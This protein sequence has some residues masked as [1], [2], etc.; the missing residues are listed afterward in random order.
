M[1]RNGCANP[2]S[3]ARGGRIVGLALLLNLLGLVSA[4]LPA[5]AAELTGPSPSG[6]YEAE[7]DNG[8]R[9]LMKEVTTSPIV[10]ASIWYQAGTKHESNGTTGLAHLLE[11]MMFKGTARY[12]KGVYDDLLEANGG[13][14][15]ATTWLDRTN[16]Y[17]VIAKDKLDLLL[18][19]EADRMRGALFTDQDLEDEMPVVRNEMEKG[20]DDP[21]TELDERIGSVAILEHP[22]HWPTIGWKSDVEATTAE[23]IHD[24]YNAFYRPDNAFLLILGDVPPE[25]MLATAEKHFADIEPGR[26]EFQVVTQEPPQKGERRFLIRENGNSRLLGMAFRTPERNH[27]DSAALDVLGRLLSDGK[28]SRLESRLVESGEAVWIAA[29]NQPMADPYLFFVYAMLTEE[30]NPD[31]V[32]SAIYEELDRFRETPPTAEEMARVRKRARVETLFSYDDIVNLMFSIGEAETV[33]GYALHE[34]YL[35][36][37]G[38]VT[39]EDVTRVVRK[40]FHADSRTVGFYLPRGQES[41]G[42]IEREEDDRPGPAGRSDV[43]GVGSGARARSDHRGRQSAGGALAQTEV[44]TERQVLD[45]GVTLLI[46]ESHANPTVGLRARVDGGLFLEPKG[47]EGVASLV[48]ETLV[49]GAGERSAQEFS[50]YVESLGID[51]EFWAGPDGIELRARCLSEDLES[52]WDILGDVILR[53]RFDPDVVEQARVRQLSQLKEDKGET[54]TVAYRRALSEIYGEDSPLARY[55][56]GTEEGI[57]SLTAADARTF[58]D[59][60]L[61]GARW[62]F[63]VVGD[64][65]AEDARKGLSRALANLPAGTPLSLEAPEASFPEEPTI[66]RVPMED[67]SQVDIVFVG[68]G[69]APGTPEYEAGYLGNVVVGGAFTS[70]LNRSLRDDQG[71]TYGASSWFE[72]L[73]GQG[74]FHAALGVHPDN[75]TAAVDGVETIFAALSDGGGE[76]TAP[77]FE[78]AMEYEAGSYPIRVSTK[79]EIAGALLRAERLG[80]GADYVDRFGERI[81]SQKLDEVKSATAAVTGSGRFVVVLAGTF[82]E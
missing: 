6:I 53:P 57:R 74:R 80:L 81:R 73:P 5:N 24:Y 58:H 22:Y 51:L 43:R 30:A 38:A 67:R 33:G 1:I 4:G 13:L 14:N 17:A 61:H 15:N 65:T 82:A 8:L 23:Q 12:G 34:N 29:Y 77:E 11:H 2:S 39:P 40:Y 64:V 27:A 78:K 37:L 54:Y 31:A 63:A 35:D 50:E 45:N 49:S 70:R 48:A 69:P 19:L 41:G 20:E 3:D 28:A 26:S 59:E 47:K 21:W 60:L 7:L 42:W 75:V 68:P 52:L 46:K 16:Y 55:T 25:E 32:E 62:T 9:I 71:L 79:P 18:E 72:N 36:D 10:C 44:S 56:A 66:I 76:I